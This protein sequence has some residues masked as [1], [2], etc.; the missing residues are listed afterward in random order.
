MLADSMDEK[1]ADMM[2]VLWVADL[3][4]MWVESL[5]ALSVKL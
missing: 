5:A 3:V 2:V 1:S 4:Y